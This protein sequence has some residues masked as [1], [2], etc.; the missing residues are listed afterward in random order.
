M[1]DTTTERK[2]LKEKTTFGQVVKFWLDNKIIAGDCSQSTIKGYQTIATTLNKYF[3]ENT[4]IESL[5]PNL[6]ERVF[7]HQMLNEKLKNGQ[8]GYSN[9]SRR[10]FL[11]IFK[12]ILKN[13]YVKAEVSF[14]LYDRCKRID[15]LLPKKKSAIKTEPYDMDM[16]DRAF[17]D[18]KCSEQKCILLMYAISCCIGTRVSELLALKEDNYLDDR[19]EI[20]SAFVCGEIKSVKNDYSNRT[21]MMN[22]IAKK[23]L[24]NYLELS[25]PFRDRLSIVDNNRWLFFNPSKC[26]PWKNSDQVYKFSKNVFRDLGIEKN[27]RGLKP[28]RH[29]CATESK[30]SSTEDE[31]LCAFI[32]H[33]NRMTTN[34]HYTGWRSVVRK[35]PEL[36]VDLPSMGWTGKKI[37]TGPLPISY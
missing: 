24:D 31:T 29:T 7:N 35:A 23:L 32:G 21:I 14:E 28:T 25:K 8:I 11:F 4:P 19:L 1:I 18:A 27:F 12:K 22:G 33:T 17:K 13:A 30:R 6:V 3:N 16:F 10:N 2:S 36:D 34:L 5:D 26:V 20:H 9:K 37:H 15:L